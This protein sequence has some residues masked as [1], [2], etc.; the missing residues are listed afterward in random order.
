MNSSGEARPIHEQIRLEI[1]QRISAGKYPRGG[2]LPS[3]AALAEEFHTTRMTVRQAL[4]ALKHRG[5]VESRRGKG[6]FVTEPPLEQSLL[7]FYTFGSRYQANAPDL[8]VQVISS[9]MTEP[10]PEIDEGPLFCV[11]RVRSL[12][13]TPFIQERSLMPYRL[14]PGLERY[15]FSTEPLYHVLEHHYSRPVGQA[16]EYL[17]AAI[18]HEP[19]ASRL[20]VPEQTPIFVTRRTT[21]DSGGILI[22]WRESYVRPDFVRFSAELRQ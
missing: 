14:F 4:S 20:R 22:E 2:P 19:E 5:V 18:I 13:G 17:E 10:L 1:E 9:G 12:G 7:H 16:T 11:V 6:T 3:E 21:R 8:T 15:D